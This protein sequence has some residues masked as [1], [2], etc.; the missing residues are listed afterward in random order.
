[1]VSRKSVVPAGPH[2]NR[3]GYVGPP[4]EYD[5]SALQM[6][7][8]V[9]QDPEAFREIENRFKNIKDKDGKPM[10]E[11]CKEYWRKKK[12]NAG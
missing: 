5:G 10:S 4:K 1:M 12:E 8:R 6:G 3:Q 2:S 7:Y 9:I 11:V